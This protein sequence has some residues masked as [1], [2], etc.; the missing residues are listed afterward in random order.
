MHHTLNAPTQPDPTQ[1]SL[2][3]TIAVAEYDPFHFSHGGGLAYYTLNHT[4]SGTFLHTPIHRGIF[5]LI[6]SCAGEYLLS[7]SL[8]AFKMEVVPKLG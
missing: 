2:Q 1:L 4:Q 8:P 5:L 6:S 7:S 3:V